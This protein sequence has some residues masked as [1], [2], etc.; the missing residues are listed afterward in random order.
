M[1]PSSNHT[2]LQSHEDLAARLA[3]RNV[4]GDVDA[5]LQD[6]IEERITR[7]LGKY[8][9]RIERIDVR[10]DDVNG[11]K[12]GLDRCCMVHVVLSALPPVVAEMRAASDREAFDLAAGRAE[13]AT[14]RSMQKH[15]VSTNHKR[16]QRVQQAPEVAGDGLEGAPQAAPADGDGAPRVRDSRRRAQLNAAHTRLARMPD[17]S[18]GDGHDRAAHTAT[19][20]VKR[21]AAGM[22]HALEDSTTGRPSRKSTR[23]GANHVKPDNPLTLRTKSSVHAPQQQ[24]RRG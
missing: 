5:R 10:F 15:G 18:D 4:G 13:R 3:V 22:V 24:A 19:R 20:N 7:H 9:S 6:W 12:G 16:R 21:D 11:P 17:A 8:A 2:T 14:Q 1:Q 23:G